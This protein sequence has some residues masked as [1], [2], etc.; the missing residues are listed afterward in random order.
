MVTDQ[1]MWL[2]ARMTHDGDRV[3]GLDDV[4][5]APIRG[6][7]GQPLTSKY[8]ADAEALATLPQEAGVSDLVVG[9]ERMN[10]LRRYPIHSQGLAT[11]AY[12]IEVPP[13]LKAL[14]ENKG[15]EGLVVMPDGAPMSGA[16]I[17]FAERPAPGGDDIPAWII[18]GPTPGAFGIERIGGFDVTDAAV[19]PSGD[20]LVLERRFRPPF[21]LRIALRRIEGAAI[22]PGA[23][24]TGARIL[25]VDWS[26]AIDNMEGLAV[27]VDESGETILT[28]VSDDNFNV[29]QRTLLL[30]FA[31]TEIGG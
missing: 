28:L 10:R 5:M 25:E 18:G 23:R 15:I 30:Q 16:L 12:A 13:A 1:G 27:H 24:I 6:Q 7:N 17:A 11:R 19:L 26:Y 3:T 8:T 20:V 21:S 2:T 22:R 4:V 29:L 9:F 31:L 14:P